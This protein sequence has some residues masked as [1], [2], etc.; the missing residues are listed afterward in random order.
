MVNN[1]QIYYYKLREPFIQIYLWYDVEMSIQNQHYSNEDKVHFWL[2][3]CVQLRYEAS[4][5][6]LVKG[7][8]PHI[9]YLL[10]FGY[11][12]LFIS[13]LKF[14]LRF[15]FYEK[16]NT[17]YMTRSRLHHI[18]SQAHAITSGSSSENPWIGGTSS[19]SFSCMMACPR[20]LS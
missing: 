16:I 9:Y 7:I 18:W 3:A 4:S 11:K 6:K 2:K 12:N 8:V 20:R 15:F 19:S 5:R 14:I 13:I 17:I 10:F 1:F